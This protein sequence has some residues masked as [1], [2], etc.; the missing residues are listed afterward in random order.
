MSAAIDFNIP[1]GQK[2]EQLT[3]RHW[4]TVFD[5]LALRKNAPKGA[6][7]RLDLAKIE[8]MGHLPLLA[9]CLGAQQ[10]MIDRFA[11][12]AVRMPF[13]GSV[14][15]FLHRWK[16][17]EVLEKKGVSI[18]GDQLDQHLRESFTHSCVL[19][20]H[21]FAKAE[22]TKELIDALQGTGTQIYQL[23]RTAAFLDD[24]G[25]RG[26]A[27]LIVRELCKN[28][29]EHSATTADA[30][31]FG[32]VSKKDDAVR[33]VYEE[34]AAEWEKRF[35]QSVHGEGMT[36]LVLGDSGVGI[37]RS[38]AEQ[39]LTFGKKTPA[40]ILEWAFEPFSTSK[41]DSEDQTRGLWVVKNKVRDLR[42]VLYV[43]TA[44]NQGGGISA[45]WDFLNKPMSDRPELIAD[46]TPFIG[47]Q[48]QILLPHM[49]EERPR[50]FISS[51]RAAAAAATREL[52]PVGF[53]IPSEPLPRGKRLGLRDAITAAGPDEVLFID[54][55]QMN[56][57]AWERAQLDAVGRTIF[58]TINDEVTAALKTNFRRVCLL[59]PTPDALRGLWSSNWIINL[60]K[61]HRV[62]QPVVMSEADA[63][64]PPKVRFVIHDPN[65]RSREPGDTEASRREL[66]RLIGETLAS[67]QVTRSSISPALT[68][69]ERN[70]L[71]LHLSMN[72]ACVELR[73][74]AEGRF[75]PAF[76]V[77]SL[78][79][80][81][82]EALLPVT[83]LKLVEQTFAKQD[84]A[85]QRV[86][87]LLPSNRFCRNYVDPR[88]LTQL[89]TP[90]RNAMEK[91]IERRVADTRAHYAISYTSLA[92]ML[93]TRA[94][95]AMPG[96]RCIALKH[97]VGSEYEELDKSIERG[98]RVVIVAGISGSALTIERILERL[99]ALEC[100][101]TV[102]CLVN[103]FGNS[104]AKLPHLSA[105]D[106]QGRC[107]RLLHTAVE[108]YDKL[109]EEYEHEPISAIDPDTLIPL[110][111]VS[112]ASQL[113]DGDF[114]KIVGESQGLSVQPTT[115]RGHDYTTLFLMRNIFK[116]TPGRQSRAVELAHAA[117]N[118]ESPVLQPPCAVACRRGHLRPAAA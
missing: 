94:A 7:I 19:P 23:L 86:W 41:Q 62:L 17:P 102:I 85:A 106:A 59:N 25:I 32:R 38:L 80:A 90:A 55:S 93:L 66:H 71:T 79:N 74:D 3:S 65:L 84:N 88:I 31:I 45:W 52:R 26:L 40:E 47:T 116:S 43:R 107:L 92:P 87:Y 12:V 113:K 22:Q 15:A 48:Y 72:S 56:P 77:E 54:M 68:V 110:P 34:N 1:L 60:W 101:V 10:V 115:Y 81:V 24:E 100:E 39:A 37:V 114:W 6:R 35:F 14:R 95:R 51:D 112:F 28:V 64:K 16:F 5:E 96:I 117:R 8:W 4:L 103:T 98:S 9:L 20:I 111:P 11:E 89:D 76:D 44:D 33:H 58:E 42:G 83:L 49:T 57:E 91:W 36:E 75:T 30:F 13:S 109:P 118:E 21:P 73:G 18:E 82:V 104:P 108:I 99:E 69:E 105:L 27:E 78:A 53:Q 50:T 63:A 29:M 70:W 2:R 46:K 61:Q 97:Y 67:E